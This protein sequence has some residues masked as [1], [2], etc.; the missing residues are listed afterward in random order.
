MSFFKKDPAYHEMVALIAQLRGELAV[1]EKERAFF[2][3]RG[4]RYFTQLETREKLLER[5]EA[6][7]ESR[8]DKIFA[9]LS[10]AEK[11][12]AFKNAIELSTAKAIK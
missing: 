2:E 6:R 7:L 5:N 9:L 1:K 10:D 12:I 4:K 3:D 11:L 8:I